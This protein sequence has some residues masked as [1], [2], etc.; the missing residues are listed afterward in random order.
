MCEVPDSP[1]PGTN[2]VVSA[3]PKTVT[4]KAVKQ[5]S[6]SK[7][8]H[9]NPAASAANKGR[10]ECQTIPLRQHFVE[11]TLSPAVWHLHSSSCLVVTMNLTQV[12]RMSG[13]HVSNML[14]SLGMFYIWDCKFAVA[15]LSN[16]A[17]QT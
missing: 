7:M 14:I 3:P 10:L 12:E 16:C 4:M 6:A 17:I 11:S 8:H 9:H 5:K 13:C 1:E 15:S 2:Q